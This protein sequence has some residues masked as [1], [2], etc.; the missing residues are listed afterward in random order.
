MAAC[1]CAAA[2]ADDIDAGRAKATACVVCH[3]PVGV[4][5]APDTPNLAGQPATYITAQLRAFRG[6]ER[7]HEVMSVM[8]KQLTDDDIAKLAAWY[9]SIRVEA[10][11]SR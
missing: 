1:A 8:A 6:G 10:K 9:A 4:S 2:M 3:G 5:S 7:K 11:P